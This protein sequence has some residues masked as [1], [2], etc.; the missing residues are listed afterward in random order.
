M[1]SLEDLCAFY[2][3]TEAYLKDLKS[4]EKYDFL[5]VTRILLR[6]VKKLQ[7]SESVYQNFLN[8]R[9]FHWRKRITADIFSKI[10]DNQ[11]GKFVELL[12]FW[13]ACGYNSCVYVKK[14]TSGTMPRIRPFDGNKFLPMDHIIGHFLEVIFPI[15]GLQSSFS[16]KKFRYLPTRK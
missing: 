2:M 1:A 14:T 9:L 12:R 3:P 5:K 10:Y 7:V 11:K 6:F 8:S 15:H 4:Q 13:K 16:L